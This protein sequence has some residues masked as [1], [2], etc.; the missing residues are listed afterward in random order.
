MQL[1]RVRGEGG[2]KKGLCVLFPCLGGAG[3]SFGFLIS[4]F[5]LSRHF[6]FP[7]HPSRTRF[8][9]R[10]RPVSPLLSS[11][12]ARFLSTS[13]RVSTLSTTNTFLPSLPLPLPRATLYHHHHP[14]HHHY[15][16]H[17]CQYVMSPLVPSSPRTA[18]TLSVCLP[19]SK[20]PRH[21]L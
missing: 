14:H 9:F 19:F 2:K 8:L 3:I 10:F 5:F 11:S 16:G 15:F 17:I 1:K 4:S 18:V 6:L 13:S 20:L 21:P 12:H 7:L